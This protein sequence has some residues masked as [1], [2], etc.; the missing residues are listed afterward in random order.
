MTSQNLV[1]NCLSLDSLKVRERCGLIAFAAHRRCT[2][3]CEI[4]ASRAMV[5]QLHRARVAGGVT[6]LSNTMRTASGGNNGLRPRPGASPS[7]A[8]RWAKKRWHQSFTVTRDT[9]SWA[10]ICPCV[11]PSAHRKMISAH[12]RPAPRL[13]WSAFWRSVL[14]FRHPPRRSCCRPYRSCHRFP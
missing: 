1:S 8:S 12:W 13:S 3:A 14:A 10:A 7:P 9:P 2:L 5:R 11:R 6:A 4:P